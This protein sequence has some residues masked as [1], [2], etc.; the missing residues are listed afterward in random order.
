MLERIS[1]NKVIGRA[2]MLNEGEKSFIK[3]LDRVDVGRFDMLKEERVVMR[4]L[5]LEKLFGVYSTL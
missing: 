1:I 4:F 2:R 5:L 3:M